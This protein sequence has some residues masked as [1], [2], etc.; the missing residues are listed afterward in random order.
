MWL[1]K[2][3]FI[4]RVLLEK[5]RCAYYTDFLQVTPVYNDRYIVG[6][7]RKGEEY[8]APGKLEIPYVCVCC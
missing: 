3:S 5:L 2:T 8:S 4:H 1:L 6:Q 7:L